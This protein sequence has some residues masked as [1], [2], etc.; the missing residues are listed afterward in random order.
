MTLSAITGDPKY[1]EIAMKVY[2]YIWNRNPEA[3][4]ISSHHTSNAKFGEQNTD[5]GGGTDSYYEYIIKSYLMSNGVSEGILKR[6]LLMMKEIKETMLFRT[7]KKNLTGVGQRNGKHVEP[8]M[9]HL[10][11][12]VGGMIAIGALKN[13]EKYLEDLHIA[14]LLVTTYHESYV[15][16]PAGVAPDRVRF[17]TNDKNNKDDFWGDNRVY[18]L[19]PESVESNYVMWKFTG[20]QKYRDYAW[21]MFKGINKSCRVENGFAGVSDVHTIGSYIDK[22]ESF[23]L[24]ETLK[25]L[26]LTFDDSSN[27]HPTEWVFNT[28]AHPLRI[29]NKETSMKFLPYMKFSE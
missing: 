19:R 3:A 21:D 9:E 20:L 16:F 29:W 26:Y 15:G 24:A 23:F 2:H 18:F 25:Y 27:I 28:E 17:N 8:M 12:F 10:A 1:L 14:D 5:L 6:H 4:I 11:T 7:V 22:Q 13:N